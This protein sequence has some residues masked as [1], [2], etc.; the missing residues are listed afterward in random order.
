MS[1]TN[2]KER[3]S[4]YCDFF[5]YS[6]FREKQEQIIQL[7]ETNA[8][9]KKN[10]LLIAP[11]GTGKT[12]IALSALLPII[13]DQGLKLIY[14]CRT[15]AQASR[16]IR[17]ILKVQEAIPD[18]FKKIMGIS[19]RGRNEMCLN[20]TLQQLKISSSEAISVCKNLRKA[21]GCKYYDQTKKIQNQLEEISTLLCC[22]ALDAQE[23]IRYCKENTLCPYFLTKYLLRK[24]SVIVC[25]FQWILNPDIRYLFLKL[26]GTTLDKCVL[27]IDECH[28]IIDVATEVNSYSLN[29]L[30]LNSCVDELINYQFHYKFIDF[31][32]T[33][34]SQLD[35]DKDTLNPGE[36]Q[37]DS[38]KFLGT[39]C[40]PLKIKGLEEFKSFLTELAEYNNSKKREKNYN[41]DEKKDIDTIENANTYDCVKYLLKF[42]YH[43][44]KN[45]NSDRY[46]FEYKITKKK[47]T[48]T[49]SLEIVALEPR[50]ITYPIY[51]QCHSSLNLTGTVNANIFTKLTG[52][53]V[54]NK[55]YSNLSA[56]S[57]FRSE[58]MLALITEGVNTK[59][60]NRKPF[61]YQKMLSKMEEVIA[62]TPRNLGIFCASYVILNDLIMYGLPPLVHKY[63][64]KLFSEESNTTASKNALLLKSFKKA[65]LTNNGA[66][67]LGVCGG[68]N[69]EGEDYPG[70]FM[71]AVIVA[72][73]PYHLPTPRLEAKI[74]YYDKVFNKQGWTYGYLFPAMQ[75]ANQAAGRP[76][77][78]ETDRKAIVFM[79]D[80]FKERI[81]WIS[82]WI[83]KE[84]KVVPD[85]PNSIAKYLTY[86]WNEKIV[87]F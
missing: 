12:I 27:V 16:V 29:P 35:K 65:S 40:T 63:R 10:T 28:N 59:A 44:V 75:R 67:L 81:N 41:I 82:D 25:T 70:D 47:G 46:F 30:F 5:P 23:L 64:K 13:Y 31:V 6:K 4:S 60:E 36:I 3:S 21:K 11:N 57:P 54:K 73:I 7:I 72:G 79:D 51:S 17:E 14:L 85:V 38:S 49:I 26:L 45:L 87:L 86:F 42:W 32:Q 52:M 20:N 76:I 68:R 80:R 8:R 50:E 33:V 56:P 43:W 2:N 34:K 61:T 84:I 39:I 55:E 15:H 71:N 9:Q 18:N 24:M 83:R 37:I 53:N 1:N 48:K 58:N 78:L 77:R 66:V 74:K 69:S 19:L 22:K 62:C